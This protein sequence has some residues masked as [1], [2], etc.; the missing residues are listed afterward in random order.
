MRIVSPNKAIAFFITF[1]T[2]LVLLAVGL[3]VGWIVLNWRRV[4]PLVLGIVFFGAIITGLVLNTIFLVRE[5]RRNEQQDS[6]LNAVTHELKTPVASIRLY[7]ETLERRQL[8]EAQRREFYGIML[9][10]T[11][12]LLGTIEQVLQAGEAR[13]GRLRAKWREVDFGVIVND[14]I[15]STIVR[16]HLPAG[17]LRFATPPAEEILVRGNPEQLRTAVANL[18]DNAI[19]YS[20]EKPDIVVRL[21]A[22]NL[23]TI[24]LSVQDRGIGIPRNELSRIFKRFYRAHPAGPSHAGSKQIKGTGLGLFIVRSVARQHGGDAFAESDG[25]GTGSTFRLRLPRVHRA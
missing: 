10:D 8:D 18:L 2:I 25:P 17:V 5:I 1:G 23:D 13:H 7:L 15:A 22:P 11:E 12:R 16:N 9:H 3:N 14:A 21:R 20:G 19:K 6:F 4:V 24:S